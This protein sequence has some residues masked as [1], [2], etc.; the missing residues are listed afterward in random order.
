M[1]STFYCIVGLGNPGKQ[2][3]HTRHNIGFRILEFFA[4]AKNVET[5]HAELFSFSR[6]HNIEFA[7]FQ[8]GD[9]KLILVKPQTYMNRSG[10]AVR[11]VISYYNIPLKNLIVINDDIDITLGSF[12]FSKKAGAA[13][14]KGVGSII[15]QCGSQDFVRLRLGIA[16]NSLKKT[17]S[18]TDDFVLACFDMKEEKKMRDL[19]PRIS[20]SIDFL[21]NNGFEKTAN[22]YN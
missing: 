13:G 22:K 15:E 8:F 20:E 21:L 3:Y 2:Y 17:N 12:R 4:Q 19:M 1:N 9:K 10:Y 16:K 14:H 5:S 7:K 18:K 6:K 11:S